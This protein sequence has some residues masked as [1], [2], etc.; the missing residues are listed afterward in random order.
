M[1]TVTLPVIGELDVAAIPGLRAAIASLA[2]G[3]RRVLLDLSGATLVDS[4]AIQEPVVPVLDGHHGALRPPALRLRLLGRDRADAWVDGR[5]L[6]LS[7][8]HAEILAVLSLHKGGMSSEEL[9]AEVYGDDGSPS[10]ARVEVC[11]LRKLLGGSIDS[12]RYRLCPDV[13]CDTATIRGLLAGGAVREAAQRYD[14]PLLPYSEAPGVVSQRDALDAW[15]RHAV[16]TAD[17][18]PALWAWLRSP[19]GC[20]DLQ[21]WKRLLA[22]LDFDDPRRSLAAAR[23]HALRAALA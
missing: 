19:S 11:R 6:R 7:P 17:D 16:M 22:G 20:D 21:A 15:V 1:R 18:R 12:G 9:A 10:T 2:A 13:E 8:R 3:P 4:S 5:R 14:G 23:V